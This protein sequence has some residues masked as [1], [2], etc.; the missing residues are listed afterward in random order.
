[1]IKKPIITM[2]TIALCCLMGTVVGANTLKS[3]SSGYEVRQLQDMLVTQGY[4]IDNVDGVFGNNTEYAVRVFQ[5]ERHMPVTGIVDSKLMGI[6]RKNN[7]RFA[8]RALANGA[9]SQY[10]K[11]MT[12]ESSAYSAAD[13]SGY[14]ARGNALRRGFVSV[15]PSVIPLGTELFIEGYGFAIADDTGGAI[16]GHMIDVAMDSHYEAI[17]WGRRNVK[18]YV[19]K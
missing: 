7:E 1:M 16:R 18:V 11:V 5:A 12:M 3:G 8:T 6:I 15:D 10:K 14:T 19:L 9:P 4:L 13:S 17:Q 2:L